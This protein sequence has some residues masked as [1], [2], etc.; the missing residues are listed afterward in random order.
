MDEAARLLPAR[1]VCAPARHPARCRADGCPPAG[2]ARARHHRRPARPR[3]APLRDRCTGAPHRRSPGRGGGGDCG[4]RPRRH[5]PAATQAA[6]DRPRAHSRR[7]RGGRGHLVQPGVARHEARA[8]HADPAPRTPSARRFPGTG[9]RPRRRAGDGGLRTRLSRGRGDDA[10]AP[11]GS[12]RPGASRNARRARSAAGRSRPAPR[13]AAQGRCAA[14]SAPPPLARRGR[15]GT[16]PAGARGA[17]RAPGRARPT[18]PRAR[19]RRRPG[20]GTAGGAGHSPQG[21]VAVQADEGSGASHPRARRRP[22]AGGADGAAPAGRRRL[23]KDRRRRL[24]AAA[25][26]RGRLPRRADGPYGDACGA[27]LPHGGVALYA[28]RRH[29]RPAD[30]LRG[31]ARPRAGGSGVGRRGHARAHPGGR[32]PRR[33]RRR[34]R[35]RAAPLRRRAAQGALGR[36]EAAHAAHDGDADP[37]DA[38]ADRLRRPG[39]VRDR[40]NCPPVVSR[41]SRAG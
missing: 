10:T 29:L 15:G 7:L 8:R 12:R 13:V 3:A 39:R 33:P 22:A 32:R 35:R 2:E 30:E 25:R 1:G 9:V 31:Q 23:G 4:R 34:S 38:R 11:A 6:G 17:A 18:P 16:P 40:A 37:A 19:G 14:R 26:R 24:R 21:G 20:V 5:G 36:H 27:A 41:S 28:A